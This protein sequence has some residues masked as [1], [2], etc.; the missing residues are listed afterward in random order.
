MIY[1]VPAGVPGAWADPA[2]I[3]SNVVDTGSGTPF[4][5]WAY[6]LNMDGNASFYHLSA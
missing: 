5:A 2:N 4:L 6:D 3:Q 1:F